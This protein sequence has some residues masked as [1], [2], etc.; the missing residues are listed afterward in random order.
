M[1]INYESEKWTMITLSLVT[2]SLVIGLAILLM[3]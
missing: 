2:G 1:S 3:R